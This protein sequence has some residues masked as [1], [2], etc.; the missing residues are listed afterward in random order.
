MASHGSPRAQRA[1][2]VR[3]ILRP[4]RGSSPSV[5]SPFVDRHSSSVVCRL[6]SVVV[7]RRSSSSSVVRRRRRRRCRRRPAAAAV[8]VAAVVGVRCRRGSR[9]PHLRAAPRPRETLGG[10]ERGDSNLLIPL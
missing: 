9:A 8:V 2:T 4:R 7:D 3:R 5:S 1:R 10:R 6:S